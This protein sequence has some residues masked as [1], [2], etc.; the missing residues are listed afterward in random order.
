MNI[1]QIEERIKEEP[2]S[3]LSVRLA[4]LYVARGRVEEAI[5]LCLGTLER[6]PN[7]STAYTI[8]GRCYAANK[9]Y[10]AAV[11]SLEKSLSLLPDAE[12]PQ[13]LLNNWRQMVV[14]ETST[15]ATALSEPETPSILPALEGAIIDGETDSQPL[16]FSEETVESSSINTIQPES[17]EQNPEIETQVLFPETVEVTP[18]NEESISIPSTAE[19]IPEISI[20]ESVPTVE[21]TQVS[22]LSPPEP[23]ENT[24]EPFSIV[25]FET[26]N[27]LPSDDNDPPIISVTL[28]EIYTKQGE[29]NEAIS[30]YKA[31][32]KRRPKER[33]VFENKIKELEIKAHLQ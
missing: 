10:R 1:F 18:P 20:V 25:D 22:E 31:L 8:L 33:K 16:V 29:F 15:G 7:Y 17:I 11:E 21:Q 19:A 5:Q 32:I 12:L 2:T 26:K 23:A 9:Q 24:E 3:P 14:N 4:G 28:A 30:I 6:E 27:D 13:R